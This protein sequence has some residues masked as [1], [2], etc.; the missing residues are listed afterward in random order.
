MKFSIDKPP[1]K[2]YEICQK[3]FGVDWEKGLAFTYGDTIYCTAIPLPDDVKIHESVHIKQQALCGENFWWDMYLS[4]DAFRL[5]QE[6]EAY[7]E[8]LFFIDQTYNRKERRNKRKFIEN[9]LVTM[10]GDVCTQKQAE[11]LLSE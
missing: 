10:Y 5:S 9:C 7:K 1:R 6:V 8:Q 11:V 2:L 3:K 4:D